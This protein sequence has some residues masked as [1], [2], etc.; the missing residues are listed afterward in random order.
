MG[1]LGGSMT[2]NL[3][4]DTRWQLLVDDRFIESAQGISQRMNAP[5]QYPEPVLIADRPWEAAGISGYNT[6]MR[7]ADGRFRMWYGAAMKTGLPQEGA[8]RLCYAESPDGVHWEKPELG[9]VP[10]RGSRANNI[11]A[12][13]DERQSQQGATVYRDEQAPADERYK[14]WTKFRPT[15]AECA[16]GVLPGLYAMHSPDGIRWSLYSGQPNPPAQACDT[17][18]MFFHDDRIGAYVGYTR[19]ASTQ[20][21]DEA[22]AGGRGRYRCI[23]RMTSPDFQRWSETEIVL[24][25]DETDLN[26]PLPEPQVGVLPSLD[27]YTSCA[28]PYPGAQDV[29]LMFPSVYYHWG[30]KEAPA[31]MDVQLLTS[32]DGIRW[33]RA[34]GRQPFL[35][36]GWAGSG[37]S[38]MLFANPW[39]VEAG[40]EWWLYYAGTSR[41]HAAPGGEKSTGGIFRAAI[42]RDGF[43][44][45]DAEYGG[46][47]FTTPP[48]EFIGHTLEVNA[49]GSAAGWLKVEILDGEGRPLPGYT[50]ADADPVFG[51]RIRH[52]VA[53]KGRRTLAE[54]AGQPVRIRFVMRDM[55]LYAFRIGKGPISSV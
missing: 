19:V 35:R 24:Q 3:H 39:L 30:E 33:Q 47:E 23:G 1:T 38:G 54:L 31:T 18:N 36:Q 37:T 16:A 26:I 22:V 52:P 12:P 53:W 17:Q 7:E 9:L 21:V 4:L 55:K 40:S 15:D 46:G 42:R 13:P 29:Y 48:L 25:A 5:V 44:S 51:N 45:V 50:L 6:V 10:F 14:L 2:N 41:R 28:M 49:D 34:G 11:V 27:F 8:I 43:V 32:R 20:H